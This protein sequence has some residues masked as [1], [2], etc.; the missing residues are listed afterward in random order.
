MKE[1]NLIEI[2]SIQSRINTIRDVQ[3]ILDEDLADLYE[4]ETKILN[5][6]VKRN[7]ERF[8]QEFMFQLTSEE[9]EN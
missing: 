5:Q 2:N 6:S 8:P 9:T 3:V 1:N 4:V 7:L